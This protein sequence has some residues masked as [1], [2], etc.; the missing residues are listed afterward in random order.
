LTCVTVIA[1]GESVALTSKHGKLTLPLNRFYVATEQSLVNETVVKPGELITRVLV[2]APAKN[3]RSA[4][5]KYGEKE[6]FDWP[7]ADAGIVLTMDGKTCRHAAVVLGVAA[8][9]PIE[10]A[11]AQAALEGKVI[12]E[13]TAR[14]AGRERG[15]PSRNSRWTNRTWPG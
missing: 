7:I 8:P 6:S 3:T 5:Q 14:A 10:A 13:A 12:D 15:L 4:Y 1:F 11:A 2:P 9:T